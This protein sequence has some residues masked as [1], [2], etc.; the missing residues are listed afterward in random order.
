MNASD[1]IPAELRDLPQWVTWQYENGTKV[2]YDAKTGRKASSTD[3]T[4]WATYALATAAR[5]RRHHAGVGYVFSA[6]DPYTGIDLDDCI[7]DAGE[8]ADWARAIVDAMRTYT[9]ISPSRTGLKLWVIGSIPRSVKTAQIEM[10]A[11]SRYFTV[12]SQQ[13]AGTPGTIRDAGDDLNALYRQ[14]RPEPTPAPVPFVRLSTVVD[15]DHARRYAVAALEGEHQKML[16]AADGERHNRRYDSAYALAG[17]LP[18]ISEEEITAALAVNFGPDAY[19]AM[20]TIADGI[21]AG[22]QAPREIPPPREVSAHRVEWCP[23]DLDALEELDPAELRRRYL[24]VL[25]E[26]NH[27]KQRV[28]QLELQ[29]G[30][31]QERNRFVSQ[32]AGAEGIGAPSKRLTFVELK[33]E[34]DTAEGDG[35]KQGEWVKIRPAYM[36]TCTGQ[37]RSTIGR[38][39]DTMAE[40]GLI[41]KQV[42]RTFDPDTGSWCSEML[43]RPLVDL[44]NPDQV[45]LPSMHGGKRERCP[46]CQSENVAWMRVKVCRD[47]ERTIG[48]VSYQAINPPEM[49]DANQE[50]LDLGDVEAL[51]CSVQL[52]EKTVDLSPELHDANQPAKP[53]TL[54]PRRVLSAA[55]D[56]EDWLRHLEQTGQAEQARV[57][58]AQLGPPC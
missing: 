55:Q 2:P 32:A 50:Q 4:T 44:S 20:K 14:L 17:L 34:I 18:H 36:A 54:A 51:N 25:A 29:L 3:P 24:A 33:K 27:L 10:Y 22:R 56:V 21:T 1:A 39:L 37:N 11:Q 41:E 30:D 8:V 57:Y 43:V 7:D 13:L 12:T 35:R 40:A 9:E 47:C 53:P 15:D 46:H 48:E 31:V 28:E 42:S 23:E 45:I 49:H 26:R 16:A 19:G 5:S 6:D 38:H 58:R 52:K